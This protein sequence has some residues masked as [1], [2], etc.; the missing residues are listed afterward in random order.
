MAKFSLPVLKNTELLK[1]LTRGIAFIL[2]QL[3]Q[4]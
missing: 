2:K 4:I 3:N 1:I